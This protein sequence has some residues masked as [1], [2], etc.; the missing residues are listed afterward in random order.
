MRKL[1]KMS[2]A[3]AMM[4]GVGSTALQAEGMEVLSNITVDGQI[5][6]RYEHVDAKD[7]GK[8][9]ANAYTNRLKL[10]VGADLFGTDWLSAYA[11]MTNVSA[12][13]DKYGAE[14]ANYDMVQDS[15]QTRLTQAYV[16]AKYGNTLLRVGR[17]AVNL[18]NIRFIGTV[19]WRQMPQTLDAIA[20]VD[21]S[22][23]NLSLLAAYATQVNTITYNGS[24]DTRTLLLNA[25]YS[26][27]PELK[28]TVYDYMIGSGTGAG[29]PAPG[30]E[31]TAGAGSDTYGIALTGNIAADDA[32]TIN[33]RAEYARQSDPTMK[34]S[35]FSRADDIKADY[36]NLELG[37]KVEGFLIGAQYEVLGGHSFGS[38]HNSFQTPLA[39]LHAHNGWADM[40]TVTPQEGLRDLSGHLGY[41]AK[42]FGT[43]K[44]IYHDYRTDS[45][46]NDY[47]RELDIIFIKPCGLVKGLDLMA[48]Y[49]DYRGD[50]EAA[51]TSAAALAND[52]R[53]FWLMADYKFSTK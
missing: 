23:E 14:N 35:G 11:E 6:A 13:N 10:G 21:N 2:L 42:G 22:I 12:I 24:L 52:T 5:R 30:N 20:L 36:Y 48:K 8:S 29:N 1:V 27:M 53:K 44:A 16:D 33:Y 37:A 41:T 3:A 43:L 45:G 18:D 9:S 15:K 7:N 19:D 40:F 39:T 31:K 38:A 28:V 17:Q 26:V 32:T 46:S 34:R 49:A 4:M 51:N 25:S 50:D 47:G